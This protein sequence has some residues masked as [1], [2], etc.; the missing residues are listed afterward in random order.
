MSGFGSV[1]GSGYLECSKVDGPVKSQE[2][3]IFVIPA[4]AGIQ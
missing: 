3:A 2:S 1:N 4:K